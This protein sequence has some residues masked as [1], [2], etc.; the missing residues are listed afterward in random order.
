MTR[1]RERPQTTAARWP[2][3]GT[4]GGIQGRRAGETRATCARASFSSVPGPRNRGDTPTEGGTMPKFNV[5]IEFELET[6]IEPEGI[7]FDEPD[8]VEDF[9]DDSYFSGQDVTCDRGEITFVVEA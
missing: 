4:L 9:S 2:W 7:R 1:T 3:V 6:T 8:G 5:T